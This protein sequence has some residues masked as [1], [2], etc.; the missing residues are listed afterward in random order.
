[1][2]DVATDAPDICAPGVPPLIPFPFPTL[3]NEL[4]GDSAESESLPPALSPG[5]DETPWKPWRAR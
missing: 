5:A 1:M 4:C 3:T 2:Y